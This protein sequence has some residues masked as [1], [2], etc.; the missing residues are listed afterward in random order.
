[1]QQP[2]QVIPPS[3]FL[4]AWHHA[5]TIGAII[6]FTL[7]ILLFLIYNLK[8]SLIKDFK[9]KYDFMNANEI[10]WYKWVFFAF[11]IGVALLINLYGKGKVTD[12]GAWFF[13]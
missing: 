12:M 6:A 5:M 2:M 8:A 7:G 1:M 10:K 3:Q 11:G 4:L 9:E 13:V